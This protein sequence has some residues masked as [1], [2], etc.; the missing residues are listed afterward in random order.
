MRLASLFK[1]RTVIN[2][3]I[4][5]LFIKGIKIC[6]GDKELKMRSVCFLE[7]MGIDWLYTFVRLHGRNIAP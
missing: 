5:E 2:T 4:T 6:A 1:G 7:V 3:Y